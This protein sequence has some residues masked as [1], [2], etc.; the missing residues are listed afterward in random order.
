[1]YPA[2]YNYD[3]IISVA[4]IDSQGHLAAFSNWGKNTVH[5]AAPGVAIFSTMVGNHYG[6]QIY[7]R[8]NGTSP[9]WNGTSMAA[10]FV[11]GAAA[12]YWSKYPSS[13]YADVKRAIISSAR[14]LPALQNKLASGGELDIAQLM[15]PGY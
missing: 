11:S 10:P 2:T 14:I 3:N 6:S 1:M 4:A 13:T 7:T 12:L 5:I 9:S 8:H 15:S